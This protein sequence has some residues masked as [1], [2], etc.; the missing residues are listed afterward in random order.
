MVT[1]WFGFGGKWLVFEGGV[2]GSKQ[3][4]DFDQS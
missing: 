2:T 3:D 1:V 4:V